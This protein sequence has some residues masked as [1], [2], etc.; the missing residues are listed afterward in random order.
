MVATQINVILQT[1]LQ[2]KTAE[3]KSYSAG[4]EEQFT[5]A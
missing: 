1:G 2:M 4:I 5:I 3:D